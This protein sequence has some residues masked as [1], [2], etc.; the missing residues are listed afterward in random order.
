[1]KK[2]IYSGENFNWVKYQIA[3]MLMTMTLTTGTKKQKLDT[4]GRFDYL[5]MYYLKNETKMTFIKA[6]K[7]IEEKFLNTLIDYGDVILEKDMI[8]IPI[9]DKNWETYLSTKKGQ[10]KGGRN[11]ANNEF[12]TKMT[13]EEIELKRQEY[14]NTDEDNVLPF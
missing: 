6:T 9:A 8:K 10:S 5:M 2:N 1:M 14:K 7:I 12:N 11:K 4:L 13:E 3:E